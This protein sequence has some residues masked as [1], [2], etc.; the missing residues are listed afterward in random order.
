MFLLAR[1]WESHVGIYD[2]ITDMAPADN[3]KAR[4]DYEVLEKLE[5]GIELLGMEVRSIRTNTV[6]LDGAYV[7][8]RGGEA[9]LLQAGIPPYQP[10]NT[11]ADYDPL[12]P[13][14]LILTKKEIRALADIESVKGLTIVPLRVYNK[15]KK[16]KI[17]IAV[18][19]GKK[20]FDKRAAIQKRETDR[21]MRRT[22]KGE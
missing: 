7:G 18:V 1:V 8:I 5:A 14:K 3:R 11:P 19:R 4:Y 6:K 20:Q 17:E 21:D 13:R 9:F 2:S 22:L 16:V 12:R 10:A 15:G